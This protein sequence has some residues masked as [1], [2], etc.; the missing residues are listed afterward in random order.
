MLQIIK[1]PVSEVH[2]EGKQIGSDLT[3]GKRLGKYSLGAV[4]ASRVTR[5][6]DRWWE[7]SRTVKT[8]GISQCWVR[9]GTGTHRFRGGLAGTCL[10]A[11]NMARGGSLQ[12]SRGD[13]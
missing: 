7:E 11:D 2:L 6:P 10:T 13:L 3:W 1:R 12:P 9:E 8:S 4:E 5:R